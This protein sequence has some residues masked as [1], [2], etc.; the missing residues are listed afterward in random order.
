MKILMINGSPKDNGNTA[1][2]LA[3]MCVIFEKEGVEIEYFHVGKNPDVDQHTHYHKKQRHQKVVQW[4]QCSL[5]RK[6][7]ICL[8]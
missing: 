5:H 6:R 1:R 3:E 4:P 2:A 7:N 8:G